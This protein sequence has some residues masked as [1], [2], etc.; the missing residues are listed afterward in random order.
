MET[1]IMV[2]KYLHKDWLWVRPR[3]ELDMSNAGEFKFRICAAMREFGC[4][5][6]WCDFSQLTFIDSSGLGVLMSRYRELA[7]VSGQIII[8]RPTEPVYKLLLASG[9]HK[10][11]EIDRPLSMKYSKEES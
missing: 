3:G 5:N 7:P 1:D 9:L 6:L 8:T 10:L 2:K 4:R 11:M